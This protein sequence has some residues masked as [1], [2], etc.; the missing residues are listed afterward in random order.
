MTLVNGQIAWQNGQV[1]DGIL[2]KW[3]K[4]LIVRKAGERTVAGELAAFPC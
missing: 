4:P 1:S 3:L 2:S